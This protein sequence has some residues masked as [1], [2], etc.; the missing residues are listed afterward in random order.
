MRL[1]KL[2]ANKPS[3]KT[4]H[5]NRQG[6][7]LIVG[8]RSE[9]ATDEE[10]STDKTYNGVGKSLLVEIIHF[11]LGSN[12]VKAF[13]QSIPGWE[14]E[15]LFV[16][17][18]VEHTVRR[19]TGDQGKLHLD[20]EEM[21]AGKEFWQAMGEW[22]FSIPEN[23][24]NL[25]F[26]SLIPKFIRRGRSSYVTAEKTSADFTDYQGLLR[27][28]FLL[29]L[30]VDL[31][32]E[33]YCLRKRLQ[34]AKKSKKALADDPIFR[35]FYNADKDVGIELSSLEERI[36]K[37][38]RD[39]QAFEVADDY[40][41]VQQAADDLAREVG[42]LRNRA[43]LVRNAIANVD[44]SIEIR[45][46][47]LP[48]RI[49][50]A[51]EETRAAFKESTLRRLED[52]H[53]FHS[54]L[55][56]SRVT[57]LSRERRKLSRALAELEPRVKHLNE[58]LDEKLA[59]L[60]GHRALDVLVGVS[61][62]ISELKTRV[63]KLRD[64]DDLKQRW[65]DEMASVKAALQQEILRTNAYL[66]QVKMGIDRFNSNFTRLSKRLYP[67]SPAGIALH[68]NTGDNQIRFDF[69]VRIE[70]DAADGINEA[71]VFCYD[72]SLLAAGRNHRVG[73]VFHDS[74]LFSDMDPRQRAELF[75]IA[76][77]ETA[78]S[79]RQYVATLNEDQIAGMTPYLSEQEREELFDSRIVLRLGDRSPK[80]KLLGIQVD[81]HYE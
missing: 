46:D 41:E 49:T 5:F 71:R 15:L 42:T 7:T 63:R 33:K 35:D 20:G 38:E 69:R 27:N 30:D 50:A 14:F 68:N 76:N 44:K 52:V 21:D 77:E 23:F 51:Y 22:T 34:Q 2:S 18:D 78:K 9:S 53:E 8:S 19:D 70:N 32:A 54:R 61:N 40:Y 81:M 43:L 75:R 64:F 62:E 36:E 55:M 31:V 16:V 4:V 48:A 10:G 25:T 29:G 17:D 56:E 79:G 26:R 59:F 66:K 39:R 47:I 1:V 60:G 80:E 73:F 24:G 28:T 67:E 74:R 11:C 72:M 65:I 13:E 57:R 6:L 58:L 12:Q 37:L 45:P 3:F